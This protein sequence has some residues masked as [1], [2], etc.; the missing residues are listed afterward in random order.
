MFD[1]LVASSHNHKKG[2]KTDS[3]NSPLANKI[4]D[5]GFYDM[6]AHR[7]HSR[8]AAA[9]EGQPDPVRAQAGKYAAETRRRGGRVTPPLYYRPPGPGSANGLPFANLAI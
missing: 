6:Q 9:R 3:L 4:R 1:D 2:G 7:L 8:V 5:L